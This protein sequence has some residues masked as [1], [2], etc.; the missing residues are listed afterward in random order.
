[1]K[2]PRCCVCNKKINTTLSDALRCKC[3]ATVC[4]LHRFPDQHNCTYD[5][6]NENKSKLRREMPQVECDK[7][8]RI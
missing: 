4:R 6:R 7:V 2:S 8:I 3:N 1:M 5:F